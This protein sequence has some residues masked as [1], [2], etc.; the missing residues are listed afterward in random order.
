M[1][2]DCRIRK[3]EWASVLLNFIIT[4]C[5]ARS[6]R[7]SGRRPALQHALRLNTRIQ[8]CL[9]LPGSLWLQIVES[10]AAL[11][12]NTKINCLSSK[13]ILLPHNDGR[14]SL[15]W[16]M[17][18]RKTEACCDVRSVTSHLTKVRL[19]WGRKMESLY[20]KIVLWSIR[21]DIKE[22]RILLSVPEGWR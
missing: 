8:W 20:T 15:L 6:W 19:Q 13:C 11:S 10:D 3:G 14:F 16:W 7:R 1:C 5:S 18:T 22:T 4:I 17:E 9:L 12:I 2:K 21:V